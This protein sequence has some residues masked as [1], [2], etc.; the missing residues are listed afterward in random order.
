MSTTVRPDM[1]AH[2]ERLSSLPQLMDVEKGPS[3]K[4]AITG[5]QC[6]VCGVGKVVLTLDPSLPPGQTPKSC[7][8]DCGYT[9]EFGRVKPDP[10]AEVEVI[11]DEE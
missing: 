10:R 3:R 1:E 6:P 11:V 7:T 8:A 2:E 5:Q 4:D 9:E